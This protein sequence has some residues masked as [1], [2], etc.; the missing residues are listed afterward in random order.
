MIYEGRNVY[1]NGL[2]PAVFINGHNM[3]IHRLEW[4]KHNGPI[5]NGFI[6]HHKDGN[7][8]N[9]NIDN[10]EMLSRAEHIKEHADVVHRKG[11]PVIATKGDITLYFSSIEEAAA[12]CGTHSCG[13]QRIFKGKQF[14]ANG[15]KFRKAGD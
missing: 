5:P 12:G 8:L 2:Y 1:M 13:I 3:H 11:I 6:I 10:L 15:W 14:T 4:E 9:W 7:K